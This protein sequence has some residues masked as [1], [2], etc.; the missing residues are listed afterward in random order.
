MS[1][2]I[3]VD[4]LSPQGKLMWRYEGEII[5]RGEGWLKLEA[6]FDHDH[7]TVAGVELKRGDRFVE[8]YY[9]DRWYNIFEI[10]DRDTD[11]V[12]GWYCNITRPPVI[13][14]DRVE[15]VDLF[16]DLWVSADGRQT[17][18]D[19]EEFLAAHLE[20]DLRQ[21]AIGA[22]AE[23]KEFFTASCND[24]QTLPLQKKGVNRNRV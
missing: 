13:L 5:E 2:K 24:L 10:H 6:F 11:A 23:L 4:K 8:S 20:D 1:E 22:L 15:Y 21:A 19:E 3:V 7:I 12:K 16:L 9:R 14:N 17:I 18:L